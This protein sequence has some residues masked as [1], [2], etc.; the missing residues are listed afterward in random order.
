MRTD[1]MSEAARRSDRLRV[2]GLVCLCGLAGSAITLL[3]HLAAPR[4]PGWPI[5]FLFL[6]LV[7]PSFIAELDL[8]ARPAE[9]KK[10]LWGYPTFWGSM[11]LE[12]SFRY[13]LHPMER[14]GHSPKDEETKSNAGA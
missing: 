8:R 4:M 6:F 1:S 3:L 12:E 7:A 14:G 5:G 10:R 9:A 2:A 11:G 13:L